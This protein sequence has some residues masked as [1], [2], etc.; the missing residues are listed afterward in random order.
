[1]M[2]ILLLSVF[3]L[4]CGSVT[5]ASS[6]AGG[7]LGAGGGAGGGQAGASSAVGGDAGAQGGNGQAAGEGGHA[8]G[9]GG[10]LG[11]RGGAGGATL[12]ACAAKVF[13]PTSANACA[14]SCF[15]GCQARPDYHNLAPAA[16]CLA[17]CGPDSCPG[18]ICVQSC[19]AC[20]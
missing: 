8:G 2:R 9:A 13:P 4:G 16:P 18:V 15:F 3:V 19:S 12:A 20:P 11:G 6:D 14:G 5:A 7:E 10:E 17:D 1:M